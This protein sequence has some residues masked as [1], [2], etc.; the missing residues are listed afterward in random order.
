MGHDTFR[1]CGI[2]RKKG[3]ARSLVD[4]TIAVLDSKLKK[5]LCCMPLVIAIV[6]LTSSVVSLVFFGDPLTLSLLVSLMGFLLFF[7]VKREYKI[8]KVTFMSDEIYVCGSKSWITHAVIQF[9]SKIKYRQIIGMRAVYS[10]LTSKFTYEDLRESSPSVQASGLMPKPYIELLLSS[11][12]IERIYIGHFTKKQRKAIIE[13]IKLRVS[14][15]NNM[16]EHLD[17]N[18]VLKELKF[19]LKVL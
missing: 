15:H 4:K 6:T 16:L 14:Q 9:E 3:D 13:E 5:F 8:S 1:L 7:Y 11:G 12:K 17:S 10:V 19:T 2:L 18:S